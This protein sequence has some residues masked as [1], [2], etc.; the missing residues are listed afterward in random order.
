MVLCRSTG[1]C[2]CP[3]HCVPDCVFWNVAASASESATF[4]KGEMRTHDMYLIVAD[5][6]V[7]LEIRP[8]LG[9][10]TAE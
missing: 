9:L 10:L 7:A 6:H 5:G 1:K 3:S 4:L 8:D 2:L